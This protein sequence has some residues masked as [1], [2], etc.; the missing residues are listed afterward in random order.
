MEFGLGDVVRMRKPH[1]CGNDLFTIIRT[2]A[3]IKI[4]CN[5]CGRIIML[6]RNTFQRRM[7]TVVQQSG[8]RT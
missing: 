7:K 6:D 4:K 3:D 5:Q 2:G 8:E 1:P